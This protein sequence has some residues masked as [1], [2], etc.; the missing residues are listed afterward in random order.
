M[1]QFSINMQ[2]SLV[3]CNCCSLFFLLGWGSIPIACLRALAVNA[4]WAVRI[5]G[6]VKDC[7]R[8]CVGNLL[9]YGAPPSPPLKKRKERWRSLASNDVE[10]FH[11]L[12]PLW[13]SMKL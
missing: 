9:V 7:A 6:F 10:E 4:S 1:T 3:I 11:L 5:E 12:L 2:R 8:D 13:S